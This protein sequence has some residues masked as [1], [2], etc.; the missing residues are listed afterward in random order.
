[1]APSHLVVASFI[2]SAAMPAAAAAGELWLAAGAGFD[3][4][5]G[6]LE[7]WQ[8]ATSAPTASLDAAGPRLALFLSQS[9]KDDSARLEG[10]WS[11]AAPGLT[12]EILGGF[13]ARRQDQGIRLSPVI[14]TA[15]ETAGG[16]GGVAALALLRP[17][18]GEVWLEA[19]PW[20]DLGNC[21]R[22]G[23]LVAGAPGPNEAGLR[24]GV[25]SSGYR[26][27]LPVIRELFLGGEIGLAADRRSRG[28]SPFAG[29]N[30]GFHL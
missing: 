1:M 10:G 16:R 26:V 29:L 25:F 4:G 3:P 28:L 6:G 24:A 5:G 21:W 8:A 23:V 14:T 13:E 2:L 11:V 18:F 12:G 22:L 30:L 19:R 7:M 15:L 17:A 20:L 9:G 27:V